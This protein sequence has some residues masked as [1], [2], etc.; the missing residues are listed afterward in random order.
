MT[1]FR[2]QYKKDFDSI[3]PDADYVDNMVE[4]IIE[5]PKR[6]RFKKP[7]RLVAAVVAICLLVGGGFLANHLTEPTFI[8]M[9]YAHDN[10]DTGVNIEENT[11]VVLPFGKLSR[12]ERHSYVNETG[13][14]MYSY[15]VGFEDGG[16]S[17]IG[18]NISS[19]TYTSNR[20]ELQYFDSLLAKKMIDE[21]KADNN[22][23]NSSEKVELIAFDD[24]HLLMQSGQK[25]TK[26]FQEELGTKSFNVDWIPWYAIDIVSEDRPIDFADLPADIIT[27]KVS[28]TNGKEISKQLQLTFNS[29]GD[30]LAEVIIK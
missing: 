10:G 12:G 9:A 30:L 5:Y 11:S 20:G 22:K 14:K 16:I 18:D 21:K 27:I 7:T 23:P 1:M 25:I 24:S 2:K 29:D 4:G 19:V 26:V 17:I 13:E 6:N 3:I 28:F 8:M 15:D